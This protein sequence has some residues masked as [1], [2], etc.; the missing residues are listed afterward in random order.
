MHVD[1]ESKKAGLVTRKFQFHTE[2]EEKS[3]A[4]GTCYMGSWRDI[5][6]WRVKTLTLRSS[7][8]GSLDIMTAMV[9]PTGRGSHPS[10]GTYYTSRIEEGSYTTKSFEEALG[11]A[12][13]RFC[14]TGTSD[15][16]GGGDHSTGTVNL[17]WAGQV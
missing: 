8:S 4:R 15:V 14:A 12:R 9:N 13:A 1:E 3:T 5:S 6:R 2:F 11:W 16:P 10:T 7:M 17:F